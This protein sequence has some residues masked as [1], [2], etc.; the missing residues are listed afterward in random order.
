M[1]QQH[2]THGQASE[3]GEPLTWQ[4]PSTSATGTVDTHGG[5]GF[6]LAF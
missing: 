5:D 4:A 1:G 3:R 2:E 6:K